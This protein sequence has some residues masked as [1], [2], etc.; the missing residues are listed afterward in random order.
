MLE[1]FTAAKISRV[2]DSESKG[3]DVKL[4]KKSDS[5]SRSYDCT[6]ADDLQENFNRLLPG[7][8]GRA[9]KVYQSN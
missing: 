1:C 6:F 9:N 2:A 7:A 3:Q 4:T 5:D 8:D